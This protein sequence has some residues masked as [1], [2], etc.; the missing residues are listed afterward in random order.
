MIVR[1][2]LTDAEYQVLRKEGMSGKFEHEISRV[3]ENVKIKTRTPQR[4]VK[5]MERLIDPGETSWYE[6]LDIARV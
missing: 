1:F 5:D 2:V 4:L 3:G 6:I